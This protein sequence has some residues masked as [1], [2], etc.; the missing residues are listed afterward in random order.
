MVGAAFLWCVR[1]PVVMHSRHP[2]YRSDDAYA[3][4]HDDVVAGVA[5]VVVV[6]IDRSSRR[7]E[8]C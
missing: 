8:E 7:E 3:A 1:P 4:P 6:R 5:D 2:V